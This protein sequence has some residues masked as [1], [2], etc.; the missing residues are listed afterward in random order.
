MSKVIVV[1]DSKTGFTE[2]MAKAVVEG[3]KGVEGA[4]IELIKVGTPFSISKLNSA[5]ALIFG[6]PT[7]Y[8]GVTQEMSF[9][10]EN[11]EAHKE[12]KRLKVVDNLLQPKIRTNQWHIL[13]R[14]QH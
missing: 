14:L 7:R 6:S 3:A 5:D 10:L 2:R 8:G 9:F 1:F 13:V 11:V 12:S 4:D